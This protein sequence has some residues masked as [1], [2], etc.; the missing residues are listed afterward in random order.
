[1]SRLLNRDICLTIIC[2]SDVAATNQQARSCKK[3]AVEFMRDDRTTTGRTCSNSSAYR[4]AGDR[5]I[6]CLDNRMDG[7]RLFQFVRFWAGPRAY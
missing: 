7:R 2:H 5:A 4:V 3:R 6:W 1:M